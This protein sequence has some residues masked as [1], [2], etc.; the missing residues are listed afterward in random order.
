[1]PRSTR[2]PASAVGAPVALL[3]SLTLL[4]SILICVVFTE[5]TV[6][7]TFRFPPTCKLPVISTLSG[8][9]IV[10]AEV[11]DP[12]PETSISFAVPAIVAI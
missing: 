8:R 1:M 12:E 5:F 2:I 7:I 4:S 11:S 3:F 9:P 10:T 6:P